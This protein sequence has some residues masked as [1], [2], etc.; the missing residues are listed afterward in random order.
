MRDDKKISMAVVQRLPRYFRYLGDLLDQDIG[1]IS[2]KELSDRMGITASQIRQDLNNFG[3]FGQQGYGYNVP[4]LYNEIKRILGL[5]KVYNLVVVGAGNFGQTLANYPGFKQRGFNFI[6]LFDTRPDI[7][8][9]KV[10]N[11]EVFDVSE[12]EK[13]VN[14]NRVDVAVLTLPDPAASE[15]AAVLGGLNIRGVWNFSNRDL[16]LPENIV[17]ESV[18]LTDSL[19][20]LSYMIN[21]DEIWQRLDT[22]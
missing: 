7:I 8:G 3:S 10:N 13:F 9:T 21:E 15:V 12:L 19:M 5:D 1:R 2:S 4:L 16:K 11:I 14:N 18:R 20:T 17:V 6:A 22:M